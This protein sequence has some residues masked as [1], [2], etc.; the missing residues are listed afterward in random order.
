MSSV[1]WC[2]TNGR[3]TAPPAMGCIMGVSTSMKPRE[4]GH[5][6]Q[7][8][9][10]DASGHLQID[11]RVLQLFGGLLAILRQDLRDSMREFELVGVSGL[12]QLFDFTQ[13]FLAQ[14][15]NFLFE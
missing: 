13:F 2:V 12:S 6:L 3:A 10:D 11:P 4:N 8:Q 7:A 1:L 5:A 9:R 15:V 14:L